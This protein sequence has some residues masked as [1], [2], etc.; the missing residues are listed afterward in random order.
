LDII[1]FKNFPKKGN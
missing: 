1:V